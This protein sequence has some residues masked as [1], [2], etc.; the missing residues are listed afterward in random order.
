MSYIAYANYVIW[1]SDPVEYAAA[2]VTCGGT[3]FAFCPKTAATTFGITWPLVTGPLTGTKGIYGYYPYGIP[4]SPGV[5]VEVSHPLP[6][7]IF[8]K[9]DVDVVA[10]P[11]QGGSSNVMHLTWW[12]NLLLI[13]NNVLG[14]PPTTAIPQRRW[15]HGFETGGTYDEGNIQGPN[16][17]GSREA[18]RT[19]DGLGHS[20]RGQLNTGTPIKHFVDE[21]RTGLTPKTSWERFYIRVNALGT[22]EAIVWWAQGNNPTQEGAT[23]RIS[24]TGAVRLYNATAQTTGTLEA[25]GS[26]LVLGK[27]YL[28]DLLLFWPTLA[29]ESGQVRLFINHTFDCQFSVNT[30]VGMDRLTFHDGSTLGRLGTIENNWNIDLDD[31]IGAD[32]PANGGLESLDS[33]DWLTGSHVRTSKVLSGTN[34]NWS[35]SIETSNEIVNPEQGMDSAQMISTTALA[36]INV[37]TD[38]ADVNAV[39][40]IPG[41]A[42]GPVSVLGLAN[43]ANAAG[44]TVNRFGISIAGGATA[45]L[46]TAAVLGGFGTWFINAYEPVGLTIPISIAPVSL[47]L[48]KSNNANQVNVNAFLAI[49]EDVGVWGREDYSAF[50]HDLSNQAKCIHNSYY[51]NSQWGLY[52]N[53]GVPTA[54]VFAIGGTFTGNDLSQIFDLPAP[55]SF[56]MIR[57]NTV[58]QTDYVLWFAGGYSAHRTDGVVPYSSYIPRVWIDNTGYHFSIT[59]SSLIVNQSPITYQYII[60]CD[61]GMRFNYCGAYVENSTSASKSISLLDPTW[62][63]QGGFIQ[64][65][66]IN[67]VGFAQGLMYKGPGNTGIKGVRT[68]GVLLNN[69]ASYAAGN[70]TVYPD[71][72]FTTGSQDNFSLWRTTDNDGWTMTQITSYVGDGGGFRVINL[73]LTTGKYPLFAMIIPNNS[74]Q[75]YLRDPS[76]TGN[77]SMNIAGSGTNATSIVGGGKDQIFIGTTINTLNIIYEVFVIMGDTTGWNNGTF[78]PGSGSSTGGWVLPP[79]VPSTLPIITMSGG[80]DFN[81]DPAKLLIENLSGIYTLVPNKTTDT[82]Y[83]N[84]GSTSIDVKIPD[85]E[86]KTGYI[87]G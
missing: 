64:K 37:L 48:E 52:P 49:V 12:G 17:T 82:I 27:W 34:V 50:T 6:S 14:A 40:P 26:T 53:A 83:I 68:S 33:L 80:M 19:L 71:T 41:F 29:A 10:V 61:P 16:T 74:T 72:F 5:G 36:T 85:P 78:Y 58:N 59:G 31:W 55:P 35:R 4:A 73:P 3:G 25:T 18:S 65:D 28:F 21:S 47:S 24:T 56:V 81:G 30:G 43:F 54:P 51:P 66:W 1:F 69:F 44:G 62:T 9:S 84:S 23:L 46:N 32:V 7:G 63:P 67:G 13:K 42:S 39:A 15:I 60:F 20:I 79:Y 76:F 87:G 86:F 77:N 75:G 70:L 22:N 57:R 45:W 38:I 2:I 11:G 8:L